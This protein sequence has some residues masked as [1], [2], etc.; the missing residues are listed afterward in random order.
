MNDDLIRRSDTMKAV[1]QKPAIHGCDGSWYHADDIKDALESVPAEDRPTV[2]KVKS[3]TKKED[4]ESL[5]DRIRQQ[6]STAAELVPSSDRPQGWIPC[7]ERM[8]SEKEW[9]E[10]YIR[11]EHASEFIV[12]IKGASRP[13]TLY[14][15]KD[16]YWFD[17]NHYFYEVCAWMPL[18]EPWKGA[19]NE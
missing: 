6:A 8:P 7:N 3:I 9:V 18:P 19:N 16:H 2:I 5:A 12:M 10:S 14:L 13:T 1:F 11:D 17:E 4:Y 15:S